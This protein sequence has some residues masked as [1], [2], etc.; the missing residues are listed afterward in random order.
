MVAVAVAVLTCAPSA[1]AAK[2]VSMV[3]IIEHKKRQKRRSCVKVNG[4]DTK[5]RQHRKSGPKCHILL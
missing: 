2:L 3:S 1:S 4:S 5:G